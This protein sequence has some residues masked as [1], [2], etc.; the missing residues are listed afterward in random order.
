MKRKTPSLRIG[1]GIDVHPLVKGRKCVIGGVEIPFDRGL[2]GHSDADVLFHA[3]TDALLGAAGHA[4]IGTLFPN[5]DAKWKGADS[6][7]LLRQVWHTLSLDGW[8]VVNLD[9]VVLA[10]VPKLQ[11]HIGAMKARIAELLGV[12]VAEV[13]VKATTTERLGFVGRE[14]GIMAQAVVLLASG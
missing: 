10:E 4:D 8:R 3:I 2:D 7:D 13:G 6:S 9:C 1:Q 5:T 12:S 14:E 11:P